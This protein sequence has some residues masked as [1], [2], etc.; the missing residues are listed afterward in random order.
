VHLKFIN[1]ND[2]SCHIAEHPARESE[3]CV[4]LNGRKECNADIMTQ[5]LQLLPL[6][7]DLSYLSLHQKLG[8]LYKVFVVFP[9]SFEKML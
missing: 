2:G 6:V 3:K 7:W 4:K 8:H 9:Q 1:I 5:Q